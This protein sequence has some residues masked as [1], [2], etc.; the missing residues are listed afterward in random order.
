[1]RLLIDAEHSHLQ[2]AVRL[3]SLALMRRYNAGAEA[4]VTNT[5]QCYLRHTE[6]DLDEDLTLARQLRFNLGC[7]LVRGAYMEYERNKS[8]KE[9]TKT[10]LVQRCAI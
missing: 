8:S 7:K 2:P 9:G 5:Y 10:I 3:I 1:M 4:T 6:N